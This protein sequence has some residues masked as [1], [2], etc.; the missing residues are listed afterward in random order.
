M[1]QVRDLTTE[2]LTTERMLDL[3]RLPSVVR[4]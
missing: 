3:I 1:T 2:S 4:F